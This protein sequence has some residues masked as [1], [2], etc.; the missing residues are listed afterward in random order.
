MRQGPRDFQ[1]VLIFRNCKAAP[2][3]C[4]SFILFYGLSHAFPPCWYL[5]PT[6]GSS[7]TCHLSCPSRC[8]SALPQEARCFISTPINTLQS[9]DNDMQRCSHNH[10]I[11]CSTST[12]TYISCTK[13]RDSNLATPRSWYELVSLGFI[14]TSYWSNANLGEVKARLVVCRVI[15]FACL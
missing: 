14:L 10:V 12:I 9:Q 7:S 15:L 1:D 3:A 8:P 5:L 11:R 4:S 2:Y 6:A 13:Y